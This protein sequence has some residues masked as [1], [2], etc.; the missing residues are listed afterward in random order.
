MK[1][2][3][4]NRA[5]AQYADFSF[6]IKE[7]SHDTIFNTS[8][9]YVKS[10]I[11][12]TYWV[13]PTKTTTD[14]VRWTFAHFGTENEYAELTNQYHRFRVEHFYFK[15]WDVQIT[16]IEGHNAQVPEQELTNFILQTT[17]FP[18]NFYKDDAQL[19]GRK[20]EFGKIPANMLCDMHKGFKLKLLINKSLHFNWKI[21]KGDKEG[22]WWSTDELRA[23]WPTSRQN[24]NGYYPTPPWDWENGLRWKYYIHPIPQI[25]WGLDTRFVEEQFK[26]H[27][28]FRYQCGIKVAACGQKKTFYEGTV[29]PWFSP[30]ALEIEE[31]EKDEEPEHKRIKLDN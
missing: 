23:K 14:D 13:D 19:L 31:E 29:V 11:P 21:G 2:H 22:K 28:T 24:L 20:P 30:K 6:N 8:S 25:M 18:I 17:E 9:K 1:E 12:T 15:M 26:V 3:N 16:K 10:L 27:I 7:T 5:T 4:Y